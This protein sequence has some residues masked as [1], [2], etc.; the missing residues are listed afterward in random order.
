MKAVV[1]MDSTQFVGFSD[2]ITAQGTIVRRWVKR[3][4]W[5]RSYSKLMRG[6]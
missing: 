3:A 4:W 5:R 6:K 2:D 1:A